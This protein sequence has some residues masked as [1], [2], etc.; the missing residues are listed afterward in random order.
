MGGR[1]FFRAMSK[2]KIK[3]IK[4]MYIMTSSLKK[5]NV[6]HRDNSSK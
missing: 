5:S 4:F 2:K 3:G 1:D 6:Y